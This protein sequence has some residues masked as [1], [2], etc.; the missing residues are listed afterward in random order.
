MRILIEV[1][2]GVVQGVWCE[3]PEHVEIFVR[4]QDNIEAGSPD[5]LDEDPSLAMLRTGHFAVY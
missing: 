5:P 1:E 2:G 3:Q 4:D